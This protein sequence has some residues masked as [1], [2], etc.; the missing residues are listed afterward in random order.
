[1]NGWITLWTHAYMAKDPQLSLPIYIYIWMAVTL[2][3]YMYATMDGVE[4]LCYVILSMIY[5]KYYFISYCLC[6]CTQM[7]TQR[8]KIAA[9]KQRQFHSKLAVT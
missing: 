2:S 8:K 4:A 5:N 1:M 9:K 3:L 6:S 7:L